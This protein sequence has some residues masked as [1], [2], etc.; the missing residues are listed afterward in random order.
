VALGV[1]LVGLLV[2]GQALGVEGES[3]GDGSAPSVSFV[4]QRPLSV[5]LATL[6][7]DG[8]LEVLLHNDLARAQK[9]SLR[10]VGLAESEDEGVAALLAEQGE[11]KSLGPGE[12]ALVK[13]PLADAKAEPKVAAA[14]GVLVAAGQSGGLARRD[15]TLTFASEPGST[16][17][18]DP[19]ANVLRPSQAVDVTLVAVNF[20][21]SLLSQTVSFVLFLLAV[22]LLVLVLLYRP[23]ARRW[24]GVLLGLIAFAVVL[25]AVA[26]VFLLG[27]RAWKGPSAHAISPRP[28]P[29]ASTLEDQTVGAAA[30]ENGRI[31]QIVI[32][33]H[34]MKPVGLEA[35][36]SFKGKYDLTP[37]AEK[38]DGAVTINV[39]DFWAYA[40][41]TIFLG[42]FTAYLLRRWFES[43][44]PKAKTELRFDRLAA[45]YRRRQ[46]EFAKRSEGTSY[47]MLSLDERLK[48]LR[49]EVEQKLEEGDKD[50]AGKLIDDLSPYLRKYWRLREAM[51]SLDDACR[52]LLD[53]FNRRNLKVDQADLDAYYAGRRLLESAARAVT[54]DQ[55]AEALAEKLKQVE[56]QDALVRDA[57]RQLQAVLSHL[58][59]AESLEPS[60]GAHLKDLE[61]IEK[62]LRKTARQTIQVNSGEDLDTIEGKDDEALTE[63]LALRDEI[64]KAGPPQGIVFS[65]RDHALLPLEGLQQLSGPETAFLAAIAEEPAPAPQ[66]S[67]AEIR[68]AGSTDDAAGTGEVPLDDEVEVTATFTAP[69]VL[70]ATLVD[71]ELEPGATVTR[72]VKPAPGKRSVAVSH[73]YSTAGPKEIVVRAHGDGSELGRATLTVSGETLVEQEEND[74]SD[75]DRVA[76]VIAFALATASG[77]AVL[78]FADPSWGEPVDYLAALV[79]GGISGEGVKLATNIADRVFSS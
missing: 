76:N 10:I 79:W 18:E 63:L 44:R 74:L 7:K 55:D 48:G 21:P 61:A 6:Q 28:I 50:G 73:R 68:W 25:V 2:P 37:G 8:G 53:Q 42:L 31:A 40:L 57:L 33:G 34:K 36:T 49:K 52:Q 64:A 15:V 51:L 59:A 9:V 70:P 17:A 58:D 62:T 4:D 47:A 20:I 27:G 56:E 65:V 41:L 30:S 60:A 29:V 19:K 26:A 43:K 16:A 66:L 3:Q 46:D 72:E 39:R 22:T 23:L 67:L 69:G 14:T 12:T 75:S 24:S 11:A 54:P 32:E 13:I 35:A 71:V 78:Y 1:V 45:E 38:G 77:M 5:K